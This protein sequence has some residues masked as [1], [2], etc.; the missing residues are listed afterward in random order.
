VPWE[1]QYSTLPWREGK[2]LE[3]VDLLQTQ[4]ST[5]NFKFQAKAGESW[6]VPCN[7]LDPRDFDILFPTS[8]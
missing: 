6:T 2:H 4:G 5:G 3:F 7:T 8:K 1:I